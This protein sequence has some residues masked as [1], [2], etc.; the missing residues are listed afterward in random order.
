MF[1]H[2][3]FKLLFEAGVE[4]YRD[5]RDQRLSVPLVP[6]HRHRQDREM[7]PVPRASNP[8]VPTF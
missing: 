6:E 5:L 3:S 7:S 2:A 4:L 8:Q 1:E